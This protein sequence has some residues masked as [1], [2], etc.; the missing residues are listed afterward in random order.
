MHQHN[1]IT[2]IIL[3]GLLFLGLLNPAIS[4]KAIPSSYYLIAIGTT[5]GS[6]I[7]GSDDIASGGSSCTLRDALGIVNASGTSPSH[8]C[9]VTPIN[10]PGS[11]VYVINLP[12]SYT[13]TL[14]NASLPITARAVTIVGQ[15]KSN[16]IIQAKSTP[17]TAT[18]RVFTISGA[19][20]SV[21]FDGVTIR[22][23]VGT[24]GGGIS[25]SAST[26]ILDASAVSN[27]R[28]SQGGGLYNGIRG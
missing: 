2:G 25:N 24:T 15:G 8:G 19:S 13:Y 3:V 10:S 21:E 1:R 14:N 12:A 6:Q 28:G 27:N 16:T 4:V 20:T 7:S 5:A 26:L 11:L 22:Y 17:N 23:G 9:N 18:Y